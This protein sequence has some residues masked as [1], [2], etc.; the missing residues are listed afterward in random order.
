M[1]V[2]RCV[3]LHNEILQHGWIGSG[4]SPDQLAANCTH[5]FDY[6]GAKAEAVRPNLDPDLIIFLERALL[7]NVEEFSFFYWVNSLAGPEYMFEFEL[8]FSYGGMADAEDAEEW[9]ER[10]VVLYAMNDFG[11][12]RLGLV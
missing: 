10:F 9:G 11:S 6:Y 3:V 1:T 8:S 7:P 12:H 4:R 2:E 5:W